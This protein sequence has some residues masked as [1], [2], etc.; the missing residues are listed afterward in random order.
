MRA[1]MIASWYPKIT[2]REFM[3]QYGGAG[4]EDRVCLPCACGDESCEGWASIRNNV[5]E[6]RRQMTEFIDDSIRPDQNPNRY[7]SL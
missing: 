2:A 3:S 5:W 4:M 1:K 6:I 7:I